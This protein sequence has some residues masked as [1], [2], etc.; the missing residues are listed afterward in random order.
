[1]VK[2]HRSYLAEICNVGGDCTAFACIL[3][4]TAECQGVGLP[5]G[6]CPALTCSLYVLRLLCF[7]RAVYVLAALSQE[8]GPAGLSVTQLWLSRLLL[9]LSSRVAAY[10]SITTLAPTTQAAAA[11]SG[12]PGSSSSSSSSSLLRRALPSALADSQATAAAGVPPA[13][14]ASVGG[15]A[16][17]RDA[18]A[19]VAAAAAAAPGY[20]GAAA[21][22]NLNTGAAVVDDGA[23]N[24]ESSTGYEHP[25]ELGS[26]SSSNGSSI[27]SG[28]SWWG[29][30]GRWWWWG[31]SSSSSSRGTA[32]LSPTS[33]PNDV[34]NSVNNDVWSQLEAAKAAHWRDAA[35][36]TP[37]YAKAAAEELKAASLAMLSSWQ[38]AAQQLALPSDLVPGMF[39]PA[40]VEAYP[41]A[42]R[43]VDFSV[44]QQRTTHVMEVRQLFSSPE[45]QL[46]CVMHITN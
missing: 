8:P 35:P 34:S 3:L 27:S 46:V 23:A 26:S 44:A 2:Q 6:L 32:P 43:V 36:V 42:A 1:M 28:S 20:Q 11:L 24:S 30:G 29:L 38:V 9:Q 40:V 14:V 10:T 15:F 33:S 22:V 25:V 12:L 18:A 45:Q 13:E 39:A 37:S 31:N 19:G 4:T 5:Y 21:T 16:A 7:C 41:A 17:A